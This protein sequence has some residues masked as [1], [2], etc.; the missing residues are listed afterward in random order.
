MHKQR[1]ACCNR[2]NKMCIRDRLVREDQLKRMAEMQMMP[3]FFVVHTYY[4]G[5]IHIKNFGQERGSQISPVKSA[6][7]KHMKYTFH[8]DTP[9]VPPDMLRT[10]WSAVNRISKSGQSIGKNQRVSVM[11]ALKAITV[12]AAYQYFEEEEK[13]TIEKGKKAD[14]VILSKNPLETEPEKLTSIQ[15]LMTVKENEVVYETADFNKN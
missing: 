10:V 7:K 9:V 1:K 12:Y 3:S 14:F 4:W 2:K 13:G 15:V 5:D 6:V 11:E 8:Q